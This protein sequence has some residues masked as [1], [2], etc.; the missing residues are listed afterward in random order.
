MRIDPITRL[1]CLLALVFFEFSKSI[2]VFYIIE[3]IPFLTI[4]EPWNKRYYRNK[5][6]VN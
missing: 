2:G 3:K 4:K 1:R 6:A 5:K